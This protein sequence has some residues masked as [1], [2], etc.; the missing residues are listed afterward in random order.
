MPTKQR[1]YKPYKYDIETCYKIYHEY[2]DNPIVT[3]KEISA[4]Y[5][6]T[7]KTLKNWEDGFE[8]G[9]YQAIYDLTVNKKSKQKTK[10]VTLK[11]N[12]GI[13]SSVDSNVVFNFGNRTMK[14]KKKNN[15]LEFFGNVMENRDP[16]TGEYINK[17]GGYSTS[18]NKQQINKV[19][20]NMEF[21]QKAN[22][23]FIESNESNLSSN[24]NYL[25]VKMIN[26]LDSNSNSN[27]DI[28]KLNNGSKKEKRKQ[29]DNYLN[30][31]LIEYKDKINV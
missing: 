29:I 30:E 13:D 28:Q 6:I 23:S 19:N 2:K 17:I 11:K 26:D 31:L 10:N 25:N 12:I 8:K 21:P 1:I 27:F 18:N 16:I 3:R 22:V 4:K 24:S 14:N 20:N 15:D 9:D 7:E 5:N